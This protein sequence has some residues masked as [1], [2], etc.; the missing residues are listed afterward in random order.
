MAST[1]S[2]I[3][4]IRSISIDGNW[5]SVQSEFASSAA[6]SRARFPEF[7]AANK[8]RALRCAN[9]GPDESLISFSPAGHIEEKRPGSSVRRVW[10]KFLYAC[11]ISRKKTEMFS[12]SIEM[13]GTAGKLNSRVRLRP[14]FQN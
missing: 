8:V 13:I 2:P 12:Q 9:A 11:N 4:S 14:E 3:N 10:R 1:T 5:I 7:Q 6:S